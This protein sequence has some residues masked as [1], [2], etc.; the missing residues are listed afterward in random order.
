MNEALEG[1]KVNEALE[2]AKVNKA[3]EGA[4]ASEALEGA[5]LGRP[6]RPVNVGQMSVE[7]QAAI[8]RAAVD[9]DVW[10]CFRWR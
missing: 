1:A 2:G 7:E 3:L 10:E 4:M 6:G 5:M 8:W 9:Q